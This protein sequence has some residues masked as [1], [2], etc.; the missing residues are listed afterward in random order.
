MNA[1]HF[2]NGALILFKQKTKSYYSTHIWKKLHYYK[3]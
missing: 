1:N 3:T 2:S